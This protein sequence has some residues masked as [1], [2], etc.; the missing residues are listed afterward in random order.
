MRESESWLGA[1]PPTLHRRPLPAG[2]AP[3]TFEWWPGARVVFRS[4][5]WAQAGQRA[6]TPRAA[7]RRRPPARLPDRPHCR[8]APPPH[9]AAPRARRQGDRPGGRGGGQ[10]EDGDHQQA[11]GAG[12]GAARGLVGAWRLRGEGAGRRRRS[13][14]AVTQQAA[15][16]AP[17]DACV[18]N[19]PTNAP[20]APP[21]TPPHAGGPQGAAAGDGAAE[22]GE[23]RR[24]RPRRA[25]AP[26]RPG[27]A[28]GG[29][30]CLLCCAELGFLLLHA[31]CCCR[32]LRRAARALRPAGLALP[33]SHPATVLRTPPP[34]PAQRSRSS[35]RS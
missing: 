23:G 22:P 11:A 33:L 10:A 14:R 24:H 26:D 8:S 12:R 31:R 18:L 34:A 13:A 16:T 32:A 28:A 25:P 6:D 2:R 3:L 21:P 30:V 7:R 20:P 15:R 5:A 17:V 1:G 29:W 4:E 35:R 27:L 9:P 19:P